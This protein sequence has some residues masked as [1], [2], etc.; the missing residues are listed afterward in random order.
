MHELSIAASLIEIAEDAAREAG[1]GRVRALRVRVGALSGV[2]IEALEFVYAAAAEGTLCEGARLEIEAVPARVRCRVCT[3]E[4]VM[5]GVGPFIC[6]S[7][8]APGPEVVG[9]R[10]LELVTMEV[11]EHEAANS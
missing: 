4:A 7:C 11:D 8:G 1:A 2:V 10:D 3:Y 5:E 6:E 9:G